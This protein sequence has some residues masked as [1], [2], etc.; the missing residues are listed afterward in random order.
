MSRLDSVICR[1]TA[2][3]ACLGYAIG[4]IASVP[5]AVLEI[6]LGSGR[7]YDHLR[8]RLPERAIF[9]FDR[10]IDAHPDCIPPKELM[11]LGE[12][13][14]TLDVARRRL[15]PCAALAHA[16][17][18]SAYPECDEATVALLSCY[19]P[20]LMSADGVIM[21]DRPLR[22]RCF[23]SLFVPSAVTK[24]LYHLYRLRR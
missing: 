13:A 8:Q 21:S 4:R 19:L 5:G 6:G 12:L 3:R 16:D 15:G 2:Q 20:E 18:G 9:V 11:L 22:G 10:V 1:L 14:E 17:I 24:R 23:D 7:T